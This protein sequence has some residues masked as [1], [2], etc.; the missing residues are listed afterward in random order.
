MKERRKEIRKAEKQGSRDKRGILCLEK[1]SNFEFQ[2]ILI[3]KTNAGHMIPVM[4]SSPVLVFPALG[5]VKVNLFYILHSVF[6]SFK[7]FT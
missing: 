7:M 1:T 4:V 3:L 6:L 2:S 5:F